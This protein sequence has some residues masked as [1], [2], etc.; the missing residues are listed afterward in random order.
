MN[1]ETYLNQNISNVSHVLGTMKDFKRNEKVIL[2]PSVSYFGA[3]IDNIIIKTDDSERIIKISINLKNNTIIKEKLLN[4]MIA[5]YG[6][7]SKTQNSTGTKQSIDEITNERQTIKDSFLISE[8]HLAPDINVI[9]H[10]YWT[11][12]SYYLRMDVNPIRN[13]IHIIYGNL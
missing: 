1:F 12:D 3:S 2:T 9:N 7:P 6:S 10:F 8:K 11:K 13:R 5:C 4:N